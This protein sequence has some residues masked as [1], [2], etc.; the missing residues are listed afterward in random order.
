MSCFRFWKLCHLCDIPKPKSLWP[1]DFRVRLLIIRILVI[2][3]STC[4]STFS[5]ISLRI[6][7]CLPVRSLIMLCNEIIDTFM[8]DRISLSSTAVTTTMAVCAQVRSLVYTTS[9]RNK[10]SQNWANSFRIQVLKQFRLFVEQIFRKCWL[11]CEKMIL[12]FSQIHNF[13]WKSK[14][15][16]KK[17]E[18][19]HG[20][21]E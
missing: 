21:R 13:Q 17:E 4:S 11:D 9:W 19:F 10:L 12:W 1:R 8:I 2:R 16:W 18:S 15:H 7:S 14:S 3:S 5:N 20:P 6:F